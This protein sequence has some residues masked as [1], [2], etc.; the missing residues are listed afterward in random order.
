MTSAPDERV[1]IRAAMERILN[2]AP[3]HADGAV[4]IVAS[5]TRAGVPADRSETGPQL[6]GCRRRNPRMAGMRC[7][8]EAESYRC[9]WSPGPQDRA[10][11]RPRGSGSRCQRCAVGSD[12]T[13]VSRSRPR[14]AGRARCDPRRMPAHPGRVAGETAVPLLVQAHPRQRLALLR[15][16]RHSRVDDRGVRQPERHRSARPV[17]TDGRQSRLLEQLRAKAG[18]FQKLAGGSVPGSL[19]RFHPPTGWDQAPPPVLH[20]Q[21][22]GEGLVEHPDLG[23][24]RTRQPGPAG[25]QPPRGTVELHDRRCRVSHRRFE[26]PLSDPVS[27]HGIKIRV[28]HATGP[29]AEVRR[30][31]SRLSMASATS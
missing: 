31:R 29:G 20:Q 23:R 5:A 22:T 9:H 26:G 21:D 30:V 1:R 19:A 28:R 2:G 18:L 3:Q 11:D 8:R 13:S 14:K 4:T 17:G 10:C 25:C 15:H 6:Y 16:E 27:S 24:E 7:R 12:P